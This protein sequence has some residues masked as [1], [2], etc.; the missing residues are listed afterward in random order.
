M[1]LIACR[2]ASREITTANA[3]W[4]SGHE[5]KHIPAAHIRGA[6]PLRIV[7]AGHVSDMTEACEVILPFMRC[8]SLQ[9]SGNIFE[10]LI[11]RSIYCMNG[12][13]LFRGLKGNHSGRMSQKRDVFYTPPCVDQL[14]IVGD[15]IKT[16]PL[17]IPFNL[18]SAVGCGAAAVSVERS[19]ASG[20]LDIS[21]C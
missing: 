3:F 19:G 6:S 11:I 2:G 13:G 20:G 21:L 8:D 1:K 7:Y 5:G 12:L 9:L 17:R 14:C 10:E 18:N 15:C 16:S 4:G